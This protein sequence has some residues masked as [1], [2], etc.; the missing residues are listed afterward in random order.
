MLKTDVSH[1]NE[2]VVTGYGTQKRA[3]V[4]GAISSVNSKTLNAQ[5]VLLVSEALQGRVAGVSVVNNGSPGTAPIVT[6]PG[7]QFHQLCL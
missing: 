2:I 3:L 1:L 6:H 7:Y 4:T 5:P